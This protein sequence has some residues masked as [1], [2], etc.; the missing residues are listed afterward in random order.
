MGIREGL[1]EANA[2]F[3]A[4]LTQELNAGQDDGN[5]AK[6]AS[7]AGEDKS[8]Q[9]AAAASQTADKDAGNKNAGADGATKDEE[10]LPFDKHPK[11]ISARQA[12]KKMQETLEKFGLESIDE[13]T[14][15]ME[16]GESLKGIL[17]GKDPK[18]LIED[19]DYLAKV[20][21]YWAQQDAL[22]KEKEE[23]L[24]ETVTRLKKEKEDILKG[25][26]AEEDGKKEKESAEKAVQDY[27]SFVNKAL[28][29]SGITGKMAE[30]TKLALTLDNPLV[31]VTDIT[32]KKAV[33]DATDKVLTQVKTLYDAIKQ[34]VIAEYAKTKG[35]VPK[36][37]G[38]TGAATNTTVVDT[39]DES[40]LTLAQRRKRADDE[41]LKIMLSAKGAI[42]NS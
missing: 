16:A 12:E 17:G 29:A 7:P 19:A 2:E 8:G 31:D 33:K 28:T 23:T 1:K 10:T 27:T 13:L 21:E 22:N 18:K 20:K 26:Q 37:P 32:D 36:V 5:A 3:T 30:L 4:A 35:D 39:V 24:E 42:D 15:R 38:A 9:A 34:E 40:K 14:E 41:V 11:W 25:K 6:P